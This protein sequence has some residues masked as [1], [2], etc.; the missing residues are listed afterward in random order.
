MWNIIAT[1]L[2][3]CGCVTGGIFFIAH[4]LIVYK[5]YKDA[6]TITQ[7]SAMGM[8]TTYL[9]SLLWMTTIILLKFGSKLFEVYQIFFFYNLFGVF[10]NF[11]WNIIYVYYFTLGKGKYVRIVYYIALINITFEAIYFIYDG[12]K[13]KT[14][15]F[16]IGG[17]IAGAFN[18]LMYITPGFNIIRLFKEKNRDLISLPMV[19]LGLL[20]SGCW[21]AFAI[22]VQ[23]KLQETTNT[24]NF[25]LIVSNSCGMC[26]C[27]I[28][29]V[30]YYSY[31]GKKPKPLSE[32]QPEV[33]DQDA[34]Y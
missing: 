23:V 19:I 11:C 28:Q 18:I 24:D 8:F 5:L 26:L 20:N 9:G 27:I 21:L 12:L 16:T 34:F 17:W 15:S 3:I 10:F 31:K 14:N 33:V 32:I 25:H 22:I 6:K 2:A 30:M 1:I 29:F 13:D 7:T 4:G